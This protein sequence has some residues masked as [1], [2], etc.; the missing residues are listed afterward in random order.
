MSKAIPIKGVGYYRV[1]T[2]GQR[3]TYAGAVAG[4]EQADERLVAMT[5]CTA[6]GDAFLSP[7][8]SSELREAA[9]REF[10]A[11]LA[12]AK[13]AIADNPVMAFDFGAVDQNDES[14]GPVE[15]A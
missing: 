1:P 5:A 4:D 7:E 2:C 13:K 14:E 12:A 8:A 3:E 11:R 9:P 6:E 10:E 15:L